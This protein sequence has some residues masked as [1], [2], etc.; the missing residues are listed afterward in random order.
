MCSNFIFGQISPKEILYESHGSFFFFLLFIIVNLFLRSSL[1]FYFT[2]L[3]YYTVQGCQEKPKKRWR[4]THQLVRFFRLF[5][6]E[7]GCYYCSR[8]AFF[9]FFFVFLCHYAWCADFRLAT[10]VTAKYLGTSIWTGV[11]VSDM[12][13][14]PRVIFLLFNVLGFLDTDPKLDDSACK[15]NTWSLM[16]S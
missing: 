1:F 15:C 14:D 9:F 10:I 12:G 11:R 8:V 7:L 5:F 2:L 16:Y 3:T 4:S 13:A 6:M